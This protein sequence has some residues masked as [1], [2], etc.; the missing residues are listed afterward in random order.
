METI[1]APLSDQH[2]PT[3]TANDTSLAVGWQLLHRLWIH[4]R[5]L[6]T[7]SIVTAVIAAVVTLLMPNMYRAQS[8]VLLP[9]SGTTGLTA[10]LGRSAS[11]AASLLGGSSGSYT[12]YLAILSSTTVHDRAI[13]TFDLETVYEVKGKR[14]R[15]LARRE[16]LSRT[17]FTLD[18]EYDFLT[19]S[20]LDESPERAA[21]VTNFLVAELNRLNSSLAVE[22]A[23]LFRSYAQKRYEETLSSLDSLRAEMQVFQ[24]QYGIIELSSSAQAFL[25]ALATQQAAVAELEVRVAA[26]REQY[27]SNQREALRIAE[28]S[29]AEARRQVRNLTEGREQLMPVPLAQLPEAASQ[30]GALYQNLQIQTE[31]LKVV[32]P[33]YEQA[34][35]EEE[36]QRTAVQVLDPATPPLRKAEPRR[37]ILVLL[38]AFSALMLGASLVVLR[39]WLQQ[40]R[41]LM[42]RLFAR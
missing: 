8:R 12:R 7:F 5:F 35:F 15:E 13:D 1:K 29:L 36:R 19:I 9:D 37:S 3:P 38:A 10:L 24:E 41:A 33:L 18:A 42:A 2:N 6:L 39:D 20:Y 34:R 17:D 23:S 31:V 25:E 26:L 30:Y 11:A 28:A 4:R 22:N 27:G 32:Q 14:A 40:R 21:D 16:F